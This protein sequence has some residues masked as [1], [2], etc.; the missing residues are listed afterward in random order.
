MGHASGNI[1]KAGITLL[2]TVISIA[3]FLIL[4][5]GILTINSLLQAESKTI[6]SD[7]EKM[8][9][10]R[11]AAG[12][13]EGDFRYC[14]GYEIDDAN[15]SLTIM[16]SSYIK[17]YLS[18]RCIRY[19]SDTFQHKRVLRRQVS[20]EGSDYYGH[21]ICLYDLEK[22]SIERDPEED[23]LFICIKNKD[24]MCLCKRLLRLESSR[25]AM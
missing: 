21:N 4:L 9:A 16:Q 23:I 7:E 15:G 14:Q 20:T 17:G 11:Y 18:R 12:L 19:Y 24:G 10:L 8:Y 25:E 22:M 13:I 5:C 6:V 3:I 2:E 1:K